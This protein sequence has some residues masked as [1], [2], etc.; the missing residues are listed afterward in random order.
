MFKLNLAWVILS[1]FALPALSEQNKKP[2]QKAPAEIMLK[3]ASGEKVF[4]LRKDEKLPSKAKIFVFVAHDCP[5]SNKYA[6]TLNTLTREYTPKG[7]QFYVVYTESDLKPET[8]RKHAKEFGYTCPTLLDPKHKLSKRLGAKV[9]PQAFLL[10]KEGKIAYSG[11]IDDRFIDFGKE[12][13]RATVADL[14]NALDNTLA[15]KPISPKQTKSIGCYI[16]EE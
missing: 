4:P 5:I 7:F 6:P 10:D 2:T 9:T 3:T 14:R 1:V 12:R 13:H 16:P 8:A 11:R 15:G